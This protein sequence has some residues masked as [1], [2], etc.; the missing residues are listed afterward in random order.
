VP[1]VTEQTRKVVNAAWYVLLFFLGFV[2]FFLFTFPYGVLK[3]AIVSEISQ[4][5]GFTVRV[6]EMGPSFLIGSGFPRRTVA[7]RWN[8]RASMPRFPS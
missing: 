3:E 7:R 5:T 1:E 2:I 8:S 4:A 6:K